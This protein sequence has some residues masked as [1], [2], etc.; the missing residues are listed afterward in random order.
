MWPVA[1]DKALDGYAA[2]GVDRKEEELSLF[3]S[4]ITLDPLWELLDEVIVNRVR[5]EIRIFSLPPPTTILLIL[6]S[7]FTN[8]HLGHC[9]AR[10]S[11]S[12]SGK[13][14]CAIIPLGTGWT[15][16]TILLWLHHVGRKWENRGTEKIIGHCNAKQGAGSKAGSHPHIP[17]SS[18]LG[19]NDL[20]E[21]LL[22]SGRTTRSLQSPWKSKSRSLYRDSSA[23]D[24]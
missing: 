1:E 17:L 22:E 7:S 10:I 23:V 9:R 20:K 19:S 15:V 3:C 8:R 18:P 14:F 6:V 21:V 11:L 4:Q 12:G 13:G 16:E 5:N 2:E 24:F